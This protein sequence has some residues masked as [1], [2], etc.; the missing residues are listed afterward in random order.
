MDIYITFCDT[1]IY[2]TTG[3]SGDGAFI[4]QIIVEPIVGSL[5][6]AIEVP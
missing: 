6:N 2:P 1:A 3:S 4:G 5:S